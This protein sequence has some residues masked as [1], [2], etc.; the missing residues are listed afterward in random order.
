VSSCSN[1]KLH[2]VAA[3]IARTRKILDVD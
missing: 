1:R 2:D 3:E